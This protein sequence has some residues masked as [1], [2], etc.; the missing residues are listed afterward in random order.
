MVWNTEFLV[1]VDGGEDDENRKKAFHVLD[2][3]GTGYDRST[4]L[5][6][7]PVMCLSRA[8]SLAR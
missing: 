5:R 7:C 8:G 3:A 6:R 1:Q 2:A 4:S